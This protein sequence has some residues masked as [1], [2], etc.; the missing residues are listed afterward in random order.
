MSKD[1]ATGDAALVLEYAEGGDLQQLSNSGVLDFWGCQR[2]II[3]AAVGL[4]HMHLAGFVHLDVKPLNIFTTHVKGEL[5]GVLGDFGL[6]TGLNKHGHKA[7]DAAHG[8]DGYV[9]PE[10]AGKTH[11][12]ST[13]CDVYSLSMTALICLLCSHDEPELDEACIQQ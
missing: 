10:L 6:A 11:L 8:I 5:R 7:I 12:A 3:D 13:S 2:I 4:Q 1:P 9:A